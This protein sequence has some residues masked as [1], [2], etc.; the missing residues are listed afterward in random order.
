VWADDRDSGEPLPRIPPL[1]FGASVIWEH[2]AFSTQFNVLRAQSQHRVAENELTTDGYTMVNLA[3]SYLFDA[4]GPVQPLLFLRLSNLA[5]VTA[6]DSVSFLKDIAPLP[7][8]SV[9]GGLRLTL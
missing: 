5:D 4:I 1:R 6:R 7:G 9:S 3:F 8:R 2:E